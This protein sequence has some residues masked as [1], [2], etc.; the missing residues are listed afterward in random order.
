M[1]GIL[2]LVAALA[3]P[4]VAA[5]SPASDTVRYT[6]APVLADRALTGL[7]VE[8][9]FAG[10]ADGETVLHLPRQWAGSN[11]L[12][13]HLSDLQVVLP[14]PEMPAQACEQRLGSVP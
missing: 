12:W 5:P 4:A 8:I 11:E 9:Q 13:R 2:G 10:E 6:V 14:A 3:S 7:T 1:I